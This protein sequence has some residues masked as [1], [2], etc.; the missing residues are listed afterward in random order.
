MSNQAMQKHNG[1]KAVTYNAGGEDI[2]LNPRIVRQYLV[3]GRA[4]HVSDEECV[5]FMAVCKAQKLNPWLKE[6]YLIKYQR[7]NPAAFV[8]SRWTYQRRADS[9]PQ[10]DGNKAGVVVADASGNL[11]YNEG[12]IYAPGQKLI[13]GWA[14][15]YRKDRGVASKVSVLVD[16]YIQTTK[17]GSPNRFWKSKPA[18]M[19]RKVALA[20][21]LRE[22]FPQEYSGM[23]SE[24][25]FPEQEGPREQKPMDVV[26]RDAVAQSKPLPPP[27]QDTFDAKLKKEKTDPELAKPMPAQEQKEPELI[28][29]KGGIEV[30]DDLDV[31]PEAPAL[32]P[33]GNF[34]VGE[35]GKSIDQEF[36][37]RINRAR[38]KFTLAG[39]K[40]LHTDIGL[41]KN[42]KDFGDNDKALS[43][44]AWD[45]VLPLD[46]LPPKEERENLRMLAIS[47]VNL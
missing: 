21:A 1:D 29:S 16:E 14:E 26:V 15:V 28:K 7:D 41:P 23:Y 6:A 36:E 5:L 35:N 43:I 46:D 4:E 31:T 3:S 24:D 45:M 34:L 10:Y 40:D 13:G 22:A 11:I 39:V 37:N 32:E 33:A 44:A 12:A 20:Q 9:H 27:A 38:H 42:F 8:T 47:N 18:T 25:E 2:K 19:I 30:E 17:D